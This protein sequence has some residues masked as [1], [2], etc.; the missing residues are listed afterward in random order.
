M[1]Q[2]EP[3]LG[4]FFPSSV[5]CAPLTVHRQ[6]AAVRFEQESWRDSV[7]D[8]RPYLGWNAGYAD[9][10]QP[11]LVYVDDGTPATL[12]PG[13]PEPRRTDAWRGWYSPEDDT[14]DHPPGL[15]PP[16]AVRWE[17]EKEV[18]AR[19]MADYV[20]VQSACPHDGVRFVPAQPLPPNTYPQKWE[21][22]R[23]E[24]CPTC[25]AHPGAVWH[26][27]GETWMNDGASEPQSP[28]GVCSPFTPC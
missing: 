19:A 15:D 23:T 12:A 3:L 18:R 10:Y 14:H 22:A 6:R 17:D 4:T 1:L 24:P 21:C 7:R 27:T 13:Q 28:S 20:V 25:S 16:R 2:S 11:Q 5:C 9:V 26:L 8:A